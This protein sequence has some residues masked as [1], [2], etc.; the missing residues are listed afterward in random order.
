MN[1][2]G[3]IL[4]RRSDLDPVIKVRCSKTK[5]KRIFIVYIT[6]RGD[7]VKATGQYTEVLSSQDLVKFWYKK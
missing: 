5:T 6:R 3:H 4:I 7:K 2:F 1:S